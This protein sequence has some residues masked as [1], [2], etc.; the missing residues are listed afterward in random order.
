MTI[1]IFPIGSLDLSRPTCNAQGKACPSKVWYT[2]THE[3][4]RRRGYRHQAQDIFAPEGSEVL[5]PEAGEI[6]GAGFGKG[7]WWV[8]LWTGGRTYY[9]AH[10]LER[11]TVLG[12]KVLVGDL[13]GYVGRTGNA[14][15][16][17]PHLHIRAAQSQDTIRRDIWRRMG[18]AINIYEELR[19]V[20]KI[21]DS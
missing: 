9:M 18:P 4:R 6:I 16:T 20:E 11:P 15:R 17:C 12:M 21:L 5:A 3:A 13:I 1:K 2:D 10:L 8:R 19:A 7:G 14:A